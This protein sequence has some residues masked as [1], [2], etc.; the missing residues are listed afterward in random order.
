MQDFNS[1]LLCTNTKFMEL[2]K[3][4]A[5]SLFGSDY[6][7]EI[8]DTVNCITCNILWNAKVKKYCHPNSKPNKIFQKLKE[9]DFILM[10]K[11]NSLTREFI[12]SGTEKFHKTFDKSLLL[13]FHK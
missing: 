2:I 10:K 7:E 6:S 8:A 5:S 1:I 3:K 4:T 13:D 11:N 12:I 9:S